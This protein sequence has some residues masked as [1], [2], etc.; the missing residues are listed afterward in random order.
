MFERMAKILQHSRIVLGLTLLLIIGLPLLWFLPERGLV[1]EFF[2]NLEWK[3]EPLVTLRDGTFDLE[4]V[5]SQQPEFPHTNFSA[6]W[7]GWIRIDRSGEYGFSTA[8]DDGSSLFIDG[9]MLVENGGFHAFRKRTERISLS[10]G[11]HSFQLNYVQGAA[12]YDLKV[13]WIPPGKSETFIPASVLYRSPFPLRGIGFLTRHL[14]LVYAGAWLFFIL[15][16][17]GRRVGRSTGEKKFALKDMAQ[18]IALS[19]VTIVMMLVM[20]EGVL[21]LVF[22][23][24]ENRQDT[25]TLLEESQKTDFTGDSRTYSLKGMVQPSESSGIVYELKPN[26]RGMF[27]DVP[28]TTNSQGLRDREYPYQKPENT[29][30][31]VGLGDSSMFGWGV[32]MEDSMLEVLETTLNERSSSTKYDVINFGVPGYNTAIEVDVFVEKCLKYSPDLVIMHFNTN[33][34]DIPYFMKPPQ[35][36]ATLRKSYLVDFL[37]TRYQA[38]TGAQSTE[39]IPFVFD[40]TMGME[41]SANLDKEPTFPERYR[42]MVGESGFVRAMKRLLAETDSRGIAVV[43]YVVKSYPGLDPAYTPNEF[44]TQQLELVT[45]L[46]EELGF[47]LL[48]MYPAYMTYLRNHPEADDKV[49]WVTDSDSHPSVVAHR[50]EAEAM[51][52]YLAQEGLVPVE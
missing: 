19:G 39:V 4:A 48:N 22:V 1:G 5:R 49:F 12:A 20:L 44:R 45:S 9:A 26:L 40:R 50:A 42:Y 6:R 24:K 41:E 29:F 15:M 17:I 32:R 27:L 33:D 43:V 37:Y 34:Y 36:Y 18:N 14:T 35:N 7:S 52:R 28:V 10:K 30:R 21:R 46:S 38:L 31:I 8:S 2:E 51:Y 3:G 13:Y 16:L 11:L 23:L 25:Q 47:H